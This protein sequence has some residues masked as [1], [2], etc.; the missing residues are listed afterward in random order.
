MERHLIPVFLTNIANREQLLEGQSL[1]ILCVMSSVE[2]ISKTHS[3]HEMWCPST[4]WDKSRWKSKK[5]F[6]SS[7]LHR[8]KS[9]LGYGTADLPQAFLLLLR[10]RWQT[11]G[12]PRWVTGLARSWGTLRMRE[13]KQIPA[14]PWTHHHHGWSISDN[15]LRLDQRKGISI[16]THSHSY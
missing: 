10:L 8:T 11:H 16:G 7:W 6:Q 14:F 3:S 13:S 4:H 2:T 12:K 1:S 9:C 5:V 15:H